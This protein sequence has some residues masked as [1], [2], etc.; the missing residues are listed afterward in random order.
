[1]VERTL[2][3][4]ESHGSLASS[5]RS[6]ERCSHSPQR[7]LNHVLPAALRGQDLLHA[8]HSG[9]LAPTEGEGAVK[10]DAHDFG[11]QS[12]PLTSPQGRAG[13]GGE[14]G[15]GD[16]ALQMS[17]IARALCLWSE[18]ESLKVMMQHLRCIF[19]FQTAVAALALL[20]LPCFQAL[21]VLLLPY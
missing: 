13:H 19:S 12:Y 8:A 4:K 15:D 3:T 7:S 9:C 5:Q 6:H 16:A 2:L 17:A 21:P 20:P 1:M 18:R 14:E 11:E 10:N